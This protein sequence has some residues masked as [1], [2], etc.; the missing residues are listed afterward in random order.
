MRVLF[1]VVVLSASCASPVS[2]VVR[3]CAQVEF[4]V[5]HGRL[6]CTRA[7]YVGT[8]DVNDDGIPEQV[9]QWGCAT[10]QAH[11]FP[12]WPASFR[13]V[14]LFDG[15]GVASEGVAPN[16]CSEPCVAEENF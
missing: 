7:D 4:W 12:T 3:P 13:E 1:L 2:L 11:P 14:A 10:S 5:D 15:D 16:F 6:R 8:R 9:C